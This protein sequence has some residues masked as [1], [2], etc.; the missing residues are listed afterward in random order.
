MLAQTGRIQQRIRLKVHGHT[1]LLAKAVIRHRKRHSLQHR[2]MGI[3]RPFHLCTVDI[4]PTTQN[5]VLCPIDQIEKP[6]FVE[7]TNITRVQPAIDN[8]FSRRLGAVQVPLD[9][10]SALDQ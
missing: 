1:D 8:G 3:Q 5:H 2:G 6:I 9:H 7:I 4:L 10:R